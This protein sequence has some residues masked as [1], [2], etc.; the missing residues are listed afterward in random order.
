MIFRVL[1]QQTNKQTNKQNLCGK[2]K[3]DSRL[4]SNLQTRTQTFLVPRANRAAKNN[5]GT[6]GKKLHG[7]REIAGP[8]VVRMC[9]RRD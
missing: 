9:V 4:C 6:P 7:N 3:R 2:M 1:F 8:W 5:E